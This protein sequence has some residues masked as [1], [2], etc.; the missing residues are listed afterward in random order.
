MNEKSYLCNYIL[1][2]PEDWEE[3]LTKE[4]DLKIRKD[5]DL[6]IFN[7]AI[8]AD[9]YNPIIQEA[10]GIIINYKTLEVVCWPFRKF[11][12][13][14]E[15]YADKIDW[16]SAKVL[17]KVDGS[18]IKLWFDTQKNDWQF[19]TNKT[20]RAEQ[21]NVDN[22][23]GLTYGTIIKNTVNYNDIPFEKLDKNLTY[24]F[25]LVSPETRVVIHY[26]KPMLY[27]LGTRNNVTGQGSVCDINIQK[28]REYPLSNLSDCI[29][30]AAQLNKN[31]S[32]EISEEGFVVVDKNW[33]RVKIKSLD[34]V[35]LHHVS[36]MS[37]LSKKTCV[38]LL[39]NNPEKVVAICNE[40]P[41]FAPAA[42]YYEYK[43]T[44]LLYAA[45][46]MAKLA[47]NLYLEY[48]QDRK[49][50]AKIIS[51][52]PLAFVG[53]KSL[54][55]GKPGRENLLIVQVDRICSLIPDYVPVDVL[56]GLR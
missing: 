32:D 42:K 48:S 38:E 36:T 49:A 56:K 40:R 15:G 51:K 45:D 2:N 44:E 7:Y 43:F 34:Y 12:N 8:V 30:A 1:Q 47:K 17:E 9:F 4:Y 20:I 10:R 35:A 53:F 5:G 52:H 23:P 29:A 13:Y 6:A 37:D 46:Q 14:T 41:D 3:K 55:N 24:I 50:V 39:I 16:S 33:N 18:I 11:G 19:S 28:P 27:H 25:E 31:G 54:D 26:D 22:S 21:A